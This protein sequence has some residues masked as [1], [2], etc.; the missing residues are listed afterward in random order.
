MESSFWIDEHGN[1]RSNLTDEI[2]VPAHEAPMAVDNPYEDFGPFE[3]EPQQQQNIVREALL[4]VSSQDFRY[5]WD[6]ELQ[7]ENVPE[8]TIETTIAQPEYPSQWT[9]RLVPQTI[10][11]PP[12]SKKP[13]ESQAS[14]SPKKPQKNPITKSKN[15][16]SPNT[17][18]SNIIPLKRRREKETPEKQVKSFQTPFTRAFSPNIEEE[19][20]IILGSPFHFSPPASPVHLPSTPQTPKHPSTPKTPQH[21]STPKTPQNP[22]T[23]QTPIPITII[24]P[25]LEILSPV[26][27]WSVPYVDSHL[28][29]LFQLFQSCRQK[30]VQITSGDRLSSTLVWTGIQE[31][32]NSG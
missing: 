27:I 30:I 29:D 3:R 6:E 24:P 22:S 28:I 23:P 19:S 9:S 7:Y 20:P 21:P 1:L 5:D 17:T 13:Q 32:K 4:P 11:T 25:T 15:P 2:L 10:I 31:K 18:P 12:P 16:K 8:E 14:P 26:L